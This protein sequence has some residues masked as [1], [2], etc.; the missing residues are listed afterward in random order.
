MSYQGSPRRNANMALPFRSV[1]VQQLF[2]EVSER[3]PRAL[4][5]R[6]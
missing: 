2:A 4:G 1:A 3:D 5:D 6:P